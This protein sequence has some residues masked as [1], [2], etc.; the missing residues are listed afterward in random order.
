M[1]DGV[2][3]NVLGTLGHLQYVRC[4]ACHATFEMDEESE[5]TLLFDGDD[6]EP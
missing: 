6:D 1:C 2:H 3:H 4:C 5:I